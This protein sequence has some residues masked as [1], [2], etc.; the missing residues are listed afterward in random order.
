PR[1]E[2]LRAA[3]LPVT[4]VEVSLLTLPEP[5]SFADETNALA[6]LRPE[7]D[8]VIF[9]AGR[10]RSTFLPQVWEQLPEPTEFLARLK[11]KAGLSA[12]YWG[13]DVRLERYTV[14]KWKEPA[15]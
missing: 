6:Q 8:G 3:E 7:I 5:L 15:P 10:H 2:P 12:N 13:P 4:R 1:F 11:Q 9:S 14:K